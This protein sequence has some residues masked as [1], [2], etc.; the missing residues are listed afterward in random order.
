[1]TTPSYQQYVGIDIAK[2]KFDVALHGQPTVQTFN[3]NA[4]GHHQFFGWLESLDGQTLVV[5]ESTGGYERELLRE[6][7]LRQCAVSRVNPKRV[8]DFAGA[9]GQIAKTDRIDALLIAHFAQ[10]IDPLVVPLKDE[11][12]LHLTSLVTRRRQLVEMR[13]TEKKR[14]DTVAKPLRTHIQTHIEWLTVSIDDLDDQID[15]F[16]EHNQQWREKRQRLSTIPGVGP[17]TTNTLIADL[18]ELGTLSNKEITA[19][20][21]LAPFNRD[22]GQWRGHRSICGGR[23]SVRNSL[24]MATFSAVRCNPIIKA[25]FER[26]RQAGKKYKVAMVA[27]MRKLLVI[28]NS[29]LRHQSDWSPPKSQARA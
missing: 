26:L 8:R 1:M 17:V 10:A 21:G 14:L 9:I 11:Q 3:N 27:C 5:L 13:A 19:L 28:M 20:V 15:Q 25:F 16:I 12:Q 22:S 4:D 24:Y 18:P 2:A 6:L 29:M 7:M 23:V